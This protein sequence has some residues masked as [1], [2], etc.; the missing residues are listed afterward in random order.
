M[1]MSLQHTA[2]AIKCDQSAST[3]IGAHCFPSMCAL[4]SKFPPMNNTTENVVAV[5]FA[6]SHMPSGCLQMKITS[7]EMI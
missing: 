6:R 1:W 4:K 5:H 3:W 2:G 7:S